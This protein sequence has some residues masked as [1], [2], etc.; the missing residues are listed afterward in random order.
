MDNP[1][2]EGTFEHIIYSACFNAAANAMAS[3]INTGQCFF[4]MSRQML[5]DPQAREMIGLGE[6]ITI[7][8]PERSYSIQTAGGSITSPAYYRIEDVEHFM[9]GGQ[10]DEYGYIIPL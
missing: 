10:F 7:P 1:Y 4:T 2:K 9:A 5:S 6:G 8:V 3:T